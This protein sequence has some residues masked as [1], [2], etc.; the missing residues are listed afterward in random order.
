MSHVTSPT[1]VTLPIE[2]LIAHQ[3]GGHRV[4]LA[5][6]PWRVNVLD[7]PAALVVRSCATGLVGDHSDHAG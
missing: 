1:G 6:G 7:R 3:R 2:P 5:A 4:L